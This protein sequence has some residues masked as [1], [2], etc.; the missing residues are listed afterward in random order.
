VMQPGLPLKGPDPALHPPRVHRPAPPGGG[1]SPAWQVIAALIERL[2][3]E[4]I[5]EPLTGR[6]GQL[7]NLD[8]EGGGTRVL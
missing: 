6:W 5:V 3:G 2:G 7:R 1:V 4:K 8:P